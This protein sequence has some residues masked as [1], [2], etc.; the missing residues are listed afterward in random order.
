MPIDDSTLA[1][2]TIMVYNGYKSA[3]RSDEDDL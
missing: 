3:E 2:L 1:L